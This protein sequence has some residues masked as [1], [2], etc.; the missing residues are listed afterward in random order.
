MSRPDESATGSVPGLQAIEQSRLS[1]ELADCRRQCDVL[2]EREQRIASLLHCTPEKIE[3]D[4][5]NV[6]NELQL[7]RTLFEKQES[8]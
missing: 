1:E 4:L 8:Q 2:K 6:I 5:R 7:L 3:H